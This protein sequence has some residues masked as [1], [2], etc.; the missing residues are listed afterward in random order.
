MK[1]LLIKQKAADLG[2][3]ACGIAKA[4]YLQKEESLFRDSLALGFHADMKYLEKEPQKRFHPSVYLPNCHSVIVCIYHYN[5]NIQLNTSYKIARFACL[6]DYHVFLKEK[7]EQLAQ[8]IHQDIENKQYIVTIDSSPVSEKNWAVKAGLGSLGKNTLFRDANGSYCFI[9]L[10]LTELQLKDEEQKQEFPCGNCRLCQDACPTHALDIPYRLD[11]RKC[12]SYHTIECKNNID[13]Q[14]NTNYL[15]GC[16]ICQEVCP[17]N[18]NTKKNTDAEIY[19]APFLLLDKPDLKV[20]IERDF[21]K[22]FSTTTL[23]RRKYNRIIQ[24]LKML[25]QNF[26][27][28]S[29]KNNSP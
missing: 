8:F 10:I 26:H 7:L 27:S 19:M 21:Q 22:Y 12:I 29:D 18:Q 13:F 14:D 5:T 6:T 25:Q 20:L 15:F 16:D 28:D 23:Y 2:F 4:D 17:H 9:G 11:A 24:R 1:S 3:T